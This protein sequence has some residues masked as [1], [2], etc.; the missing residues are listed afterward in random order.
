VHFT[1]QYPIDTHYD[2]RLADP[3]N[4]VKLAQAA[5]AAGFKAIAFTEH[6]APDATWAGQVGHDSLDV[7]SALAFVAAVTTH[8]RVMTYLLVLPYRNPLLTAKAVATVDRLSRGRLT[9]VAGA[10][11]LR[12]EFGAL[13]VPFE[14]RNELFDEA[15]TVLREVW[16]GEP[17]TFRGTRFAATEAV[18]RPGPAQ[19]GGIPLWISGN[20]TQARQRAA[21]HDGWSPL[22][23]LPSPYSGPR[24]PAITTFSQL[25]DGIDHVKMLTDRAGRDPDRL[26]FQVRTHKSA[27]PLTEALVGE[28]LDHLNSVKH[29]GATWYVFQPPTVSAAAAL[30]GIE[31][32]QSVIEATR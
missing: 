12:S 25:Q 32:Y 6:P 1:L 4:V 16:A 21:L 14:L 9:I 11:H 7:T 26:D 15:L 19:Q 31:Q 5:E 28:H 24:T 17:L 30:E 23:S 2:V 29:A 10:G 27:R 18:S 8:I 22:M 20:S 13:E 3:E